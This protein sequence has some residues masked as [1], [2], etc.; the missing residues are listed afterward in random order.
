MAAN[1]WTSTQRLQWQSTKQELNDIRKNLEDGV[2]AQQYPLPERRLLSIFFNQQITKLGK[3]LQMRQQVLATAQLYLRRF[4]T[5]IDIRQTN[6]YLVMATALYLAGK[7]EESPQHI[8][9]VVTEARNFWPADLMTSETTKLGECEFS[10]ISEMNSQLI[11]HHPYRTLAELHT[12]H[13]LS[14]EENFISWSIINDHYLTDLPLMYAPHVIAIAAMFMAV[15]LRPS[16]TSASMAAAMSAAAA[17]TGGGSGGAGAG[18]AHGKGASQQQ[19]QPQAPTQQQNKVQKLMAWLAN[20]QVEIESVIDCSQEII[21]LY[22]VWE[23]YS[24]KICKEQIA[25]FV[26]GR[27]LDK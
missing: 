7:M 1:F 22:D 5:K 2:L 15:I 13:Q 6:P 8:R 25:K 11:V 17:S 27:G 10:L 21:S 26:K 14:Q 18:G 24:E 20:S 19:Q 9:M 4:Y 12:T 3:R 16:S 23:Q